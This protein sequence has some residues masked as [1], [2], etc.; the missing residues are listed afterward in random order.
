MG[1]WTFGLKGVWGFDVFG[2]RSFGLIEPS[3]RGLTSFGEKKRAQYLTGCWG[4][5]SGWGRAYYALSEGRAF[6]GL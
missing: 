6:T 3:S 1:I 5:D 4:L 2:G